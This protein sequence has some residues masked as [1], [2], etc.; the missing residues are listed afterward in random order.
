MGAEVAQSNIIEHSSQPTET[1]GRYGDLLGLAEDFGI[2]SDRIPRAI[3]NQDP[4][5][6]FK[7]LALKIKA[8]VDRVPDEAL[9]LTQRRS[10]KPAILRNMFVRYYGLDGNPPSTF[11]KLET[12]L[13]AD[14]KR[15]L[16]YKVKRFCKTYLLS[17]PLP[18]S[19]W[20]GDGAVSKYYN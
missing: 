10:P 7:E 3:F 6:H 16:V 20:D 11:S 13:S 14:R 1:Y 5:R 2:R 9:Q 15:E 18:N 4:S 8:E 12:E 17:H 19:N